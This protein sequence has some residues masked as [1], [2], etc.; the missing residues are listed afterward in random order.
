LN[1]YIFPT[2]KVKVS[3]FQTG[4]QVH[5]QLIEGQISIYAHEN[6][7]SVRPAIGTIVKQISLMELDDECL[8]LFPYLEEAQAYEVDVD[9]KIYGAL[10]WPADTQKE[11]YD[12][13]DGL[14][15]VAIMTKQIPSLI[16]GLVSSEK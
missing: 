12:I 3:N 9:G 14:M 10:G 15:Y 5:I 11:D 6:K 4:D 16:Q 2:K 13:S 7:L 1:D 8:K